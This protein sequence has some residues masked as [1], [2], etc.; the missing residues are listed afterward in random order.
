MRLIL[1]QKCRISG[2]S[3]AGAKPKDKAKKGKTLEELE[4]E[5]GGVVKE[6]QVPM[7]QIKRAQKRK[8][9][10]TAGVL[11]AEYKSPQN[12]MDVPV[13]AHRWFH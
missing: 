3:A 7:A 12:Q 11:L 13:G 8:G 1:A 10:R 5:E 6:S 9:E 4:Q 2:K